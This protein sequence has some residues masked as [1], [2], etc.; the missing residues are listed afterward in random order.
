MNCSVVSLEKYPPIREEIM[1]SS[2]RAHLNNSHK[3]AHAGEV[4]IHDLSWSNEN[5]QLYPNGID[6]E[7]AKT[8]FV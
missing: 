4:R 1:D 5:H 8:I 6:I 7:T 2:P 3:E